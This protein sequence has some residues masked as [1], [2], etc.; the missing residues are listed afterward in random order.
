[1]YKSADEFMAYV[2]VELYE[3]LLSYGNNFVSRRYPNRDDIIHDA[4]ANVF[5]VAKKSYMTIRD[6]EHERLRRWLFKVM[7]HRLKQYTAKS[8]NHYGRYAYMP[9]TEIRSADT[10]DMFLEWE[11][12]D[13]LAGALREL[14]GTLKDTVDEAVYQEIFINSLKEKEI[15]EK[16]DLSP[17]VVRGRSYRMRKRF[18][19][20]LEKFLSVIACILVLLMAV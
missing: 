14:K 8:K 4:I 15:A 9:N 2:F 20:I 1:M 7:E 3:D 16:H 11:A 5:A 10:R 17:G 13:S 12:D 6:Y 19:K 18:R